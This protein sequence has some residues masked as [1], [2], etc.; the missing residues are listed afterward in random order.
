VPNASWLWPYSYHTKIAGFYALWR[1]ADCLRRRIECQ[2]VY[3]NGKEVSSV[4]I[5]S[6]FI[7]ENMGEKAKKQ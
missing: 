1:L 6:N 3:Q 4:V 5:L 2:P 7:R